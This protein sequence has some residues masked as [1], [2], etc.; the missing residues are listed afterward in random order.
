LT[1]PLA[2]AGERGKKGRSL[3]RL[4]YKKTCKSSPWKGEK[5]RG[6]TVHFLSWVVKK[7]GRKKERVYSDHRGGGRPD[8]SLLRL[9]AEKKG[10]RPQERESS[11]FTDSSGEVDSQGTK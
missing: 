10:K 4:R 1:I 7:G 5:K 3:H 9:D 11:L 2:K 8:W 6:K